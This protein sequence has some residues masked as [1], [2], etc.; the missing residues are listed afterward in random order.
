MRYAV[1]I[2]RLAQK[3]LALLPLKDYEQVRETIRN[4]A[5]IPRPPGCQKLTA[6]EGWRL[7]VGK[8]RIIYEIDDQHQAVLVLHIGHRRDV[9]R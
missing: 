4:L 8:Y 7:R 9:Y 6:R 1:S 2:L 5:R 3:E